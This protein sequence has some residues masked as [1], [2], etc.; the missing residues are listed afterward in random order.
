MLVPKHVGDVRGQTHLDFL[1]YI[2]QIGTS[3]DFRPWFQGIDQVLELRLVHHLNEAHDLYG[4]GVIEWVCFN[5]A[6]TKQVK[7]ERND[8]GWRGMR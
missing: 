8:R 5:K 3:W 1:Q 6:C 7:F 4:I 2:N